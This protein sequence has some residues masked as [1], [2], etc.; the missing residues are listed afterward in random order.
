MPPVSTHIYLAQSV[1]ELA[2]VELNAAFSGQQQL[3]ALRGHA[4]LLFIH[5][6][7]LSTHEYTILRN[8][9]HTYGRANN[10]YVFVDGGQV[11]FLQPAGLE[12]SV[13]LVSKLVDL[14]LL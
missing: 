12:Q 5:V 6:H 7:C 10:T 14:R 13:P 2:V 4:V 8:T 11:N 9:G 1:G 3:A